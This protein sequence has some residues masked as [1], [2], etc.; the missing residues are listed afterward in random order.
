M[1][2]GSRDENRSTGGLAGSSQVVISGPKTEEPEQIQRRLILS[3]KSICLSLD[4]MGDHDNQV[5]HQGPHRRH[6]FHV[7]NLCVFSS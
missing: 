2:Q 6:L 1:A 5:D 4:I 7:N 3:Q